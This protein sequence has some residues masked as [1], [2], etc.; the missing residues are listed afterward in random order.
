PTGIQ[1]AIIKTRFQRH[2]L[3]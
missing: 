1:K 2:A 3:E